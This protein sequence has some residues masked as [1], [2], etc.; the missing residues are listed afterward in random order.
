MSNGLKQKIELFTKGI[1]AKFVLMFIAVGLV[2]V[3]GLSYLIFDRVPEEIEAYMVASY[4][5]ILL[6]TSENIELKLQ[7][8][9]LITKTIYEYGLSDNDTLAEALRGQDYNNLPRESIKILEDYMRSL[10]YSDSYME[11]VLFLEP[12]GKMFHYYSKSASYYY[13]DVELDYFDKFE[14]IYRDNR[15]LTILPTHS[16]DY[17]DQ[18][19][20]QVVTFARNYLDVNYLPESEHLAAI[21]WIDVNL[22]FVKDI[23]EHMDLKDNGTIF[24][25]DTTGYDIFQSEEDP[26]ISGYD[27]YGSMADVID[28]QQAG[29]QIID[30]QFIFFQ[31]I[32]GSDWMI[33]YRVDKSNIMYLID[34]L[35]AVTIILLGAIM[36]ALLFIAVTFSNNLSRPIRS[37]IDQMN[38]VAGGNLT[39]RVSVKAS[40]EVNQL[41]EAFNRMIEQLRSYINQAYGAKIKQREAELNAIKT[42]IRPHYLYN[43]LE[44][45][46]MSALEEGADETREMIVSLSEQLK[47]VIGQFGD[48][49][50]LAM[51]LEMIE[52]YF[53]IIR[54][55][56][57]GRISLEIDVAKDFYRVKLL[58]LLLQPLVE[59]AVIHG[60]KVKK[61]KGKVKVSAKKAQGVLELQVIDDGIGMDDTT[62][63]KINQLLKSERMGNELDGNWEN[64]G[65][66]NVHDRIQMTYGEAYGLSVSS[67]KRL[68]TKMSIRIPIE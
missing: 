43:T 54:V 38:E 34:D 10:L 50:T 31:K 65:L 67:K 53:K 49:V 26:S 66:K 63:Q 14:Q 37:I 21:L 25:L 55:R 23:I 12:D 59:N 64:I 47:Y 18:A 20:K 17:F 7:S 5:E 3:M 32:D 57:E 24:V 46:R 60:L 39:S 13:E 9:D 1:F 2:P 35:R 40:Y 44:I 36:I 28:G 29:Y 4:E 22:G 62:M 41:A 6:F 33:L 16:E 8:Y 19:D 52:N 56:Y 48:Q 30:D 58:K 11:N 45:I 61:G 51:E 27:L 42:Q 68:G 15:S